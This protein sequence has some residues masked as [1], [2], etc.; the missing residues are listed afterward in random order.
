[1]LCFD[2]D[3]VLLQAFLLGIAFEKNC[4]DTVINPL[5][6]TLLEFNVLVA[7]LIPVNGERSPVSSQREIANETSKQKRDRKL[8]R[9]TKD[10]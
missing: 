9:I 8:S 10:G 3:H 4:K 7:R 2:T 5:P 1:M 6:I